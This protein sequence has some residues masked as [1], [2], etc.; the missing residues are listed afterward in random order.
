MAFAQ[1]TKKNDKKTV[2]QT[3]KAEATT[4]TDTAV[5]AAAPE[6]TSSIAVVTDEDKNASVEKS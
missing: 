1:N 5:Q 4:A 2:E 3:E 6:T